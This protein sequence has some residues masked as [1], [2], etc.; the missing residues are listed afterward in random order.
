MVHHSASDFLTIISLSTYWLNLTPPQQLIP[1][2]SGWLLDPPKI[3]HHIS[4]SISEYTLCC[5]WTCTYAIKAQESSAI[6]FTACFYSIVFTSLVWRQTPKGSHFPGDNCWA[7]DVPPTP[8]VLWASGTETSGFC[9]LCI[10]CPIKYTDHLVHWYVL[11]VPLWDKW[12]IHLHIHNSVL[13]SQACSFYSIIS[14]Y[15]VWN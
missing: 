1:E 9:M 14:F 7:V 3:L 2:F 4:K 11:N 15:R 10:K 6:H 5:E 12:H 13:A 8:T